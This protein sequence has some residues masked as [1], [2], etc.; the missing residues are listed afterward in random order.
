[1]TGAAWA[2]SADGVVKEFNKDTR[3]VTMEDGKSYTVPADVALPA[4]LAAGMKVT[5]TTADD[6]ATKVTALTM[7]AM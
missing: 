4:D 3:V 2:A 5:V 6:D 1:M 7:S